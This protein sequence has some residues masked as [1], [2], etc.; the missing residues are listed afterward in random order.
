MQEVGAHRRENTL[1]PAELGSLPQTPPVL[2]Q[3]RLELQG[4]HEEGAPSPRPPP[5][6]RAP[7]E[8]SRQAPVRG[9]SPPAEPAWAAGDPRG[10]RAWGAGEREP[11][12]GGGGGGHQR[13]ELLQVVAERRRALAGHQ[14]KRE[15]HREPGAVD[16]RASLPDPRR[17]DVPRG[18][19]E[20]GS[21]AGPGPAPTA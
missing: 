18:R 3:L 16:A 5:E 2:H 15:E 17:G 19:A 8:R 12:R 10:A 21:P 13:Q 7:R 9:D 4:P 1:R 11:R 14:R 6:C 20:Q